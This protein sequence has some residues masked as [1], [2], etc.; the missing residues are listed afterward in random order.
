MPVDPDKD[1]E[2]QG[3]VEQRECDRL[4]GDLGL[5]DA[6]LRLPTPPYPAHAS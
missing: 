2:G 3:D 1:A 5:T 6:A 4:L